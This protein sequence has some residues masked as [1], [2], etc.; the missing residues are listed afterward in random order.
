MSV[1]LNLWLFYPCEIFGT[2]H[3]TL[4]WKMFVQVFSRLTHL[5]I[6]EIVCVHINLIRKVFKYWAAVKVTTTDP[7]FP[8]F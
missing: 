2:S 3:I 5:I 8:K 4:L 1:Y 6:K 7:S